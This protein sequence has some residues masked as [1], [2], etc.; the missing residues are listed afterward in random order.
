MGC[1]NQTVWTEFVLLGIPYPQQL[2]MP[3]FL[4]FLLVYLLSVTGN[5]LILLTV[6]SKSNLQK[7]MYWF[8][9]HL[10]VM[11]ISVS[12]I[13][14]QKVIGGFVEGGRII[15][16]ESCLTQLFFYHFVAC[17]EFFLYTVMAYDRFLAICKPLHYSVLMNERMCLCLSLGTWF[18]GCV[19]SIMVTSLSYSLPYGPKNEVDFIVCEILSLLKL[20]CSDTWFEEIFILVDIGLVAIT[21]VF[22]IAMS[23][24][25]I[26][27]TVLKIPS[28]EG[29]QRAF[30]TCS[31]HLMVVMICYIP[32]AFNYLR[33]ETQDLLS[34]V[35]G[36][37]YTTWTPF[38]NPLIYTLR[39]KEMKDSMLS[40]IYK[41]RKF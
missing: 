3:L 19:H 15:S 25:Y 6:A 10:A 9:C 39:N 23:Y 26:V 5:I 41:I 8:L 30:S 21:C 37:F 29:R 35:I 16:F 7:P 31:S 2:Y 12:S 36:L 14:V 27:T 32:V 20:A 17:S 38:L 18:G 33:R 1:E 13:V 22:L 24:I 34:G 28:A 40:L 4:L 11:D